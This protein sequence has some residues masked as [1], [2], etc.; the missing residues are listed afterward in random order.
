MREIEDFV[1]RIF[2]Q[3]EREIWLTFCAVNFEGI[4]GNM[5]GSILRKEG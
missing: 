4:W 3:V 2:R 1:E 5:G